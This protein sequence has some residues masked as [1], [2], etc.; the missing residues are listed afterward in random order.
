MDRQ[1]VAPKVVL[2]AE[3][4]LGTGVGWGGSGARPSVAN[5]Y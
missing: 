5:F 3:E 4:Q 1:G 2:I